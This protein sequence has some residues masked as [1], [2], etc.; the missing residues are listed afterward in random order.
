[1]HLNATPTADVFNV[2]C[3]HKVVSRG[4]LIQQAYREWKQ[5]FH[6]ITT[7][8]SKSQALETQSK[9][10][11]TPANTAALLNYRQEL[12]LLLMA[13]QKKALKNYKAKFYSQSNRAGKLLVSQLKNRQTKS[14]LSS[15][16]HPL[17]GN[18]VYHPKHIANTFWH[19]YYSLYNLPEDV[20][21]P[22]PCEESISSYLNSVPLPSVT[23]NVLVALN[24]PISIE[25]TNLEKMDSRQNITKH[26]VTPYLPI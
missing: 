18:T 23:S 6:A 14:N 21:T 17:D 24:A 3:A 13:D 10:S 8:L 7:L 16:Q 2:W 25:E 11:T 4:L 15:I 19:Y 20:E 9:N 26:L 22:Q 5:R 1:M 12:R